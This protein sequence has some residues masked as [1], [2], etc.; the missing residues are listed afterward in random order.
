MILKVYPRVEALPLVK[1]AVL[2]GGGIGPEVI[3]ASLPVIDAAA[4]KAGLKL[5][6]EEA[7][8]GGAAYDA[9]GTP[10]PK[11]TLRLCD[12]AAAIYFG[13]VGG[14]KYDKIPDPNLRPERGS[15]LPLRKRY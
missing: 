2:G 3:H 4:R 13:S 1:N 7:L 14:P 11:S 10:L 15:L 8:V 12:S 5:H 6:F 9:S